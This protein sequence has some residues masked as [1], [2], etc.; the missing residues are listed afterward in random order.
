MLVG[1]I[2]VLAAVVAVVAVL[3][4]DTTGRKGSGLG[5]EFTYDLSKLRKIDPR[6]VGYEEADGIEL[7]LDEPRGLALGTDGRILA[8]GDRKILVFDKGGAQLSEVKLTGSPQC[9]AVASDGTLYVAM[10]DHV[11]VHDPSGKPKATWD[12]LGKDAVLTGIAV[13]DNDVF[14]ADAGNRVVVRYDA[15]GKLLGRIGQKDKD[16]N[17]PGILVP[18]PYM[19]LAVGAEGLLW[20][21]NPGRR[22]V[23]AYTFDGDRESSWGK[24]SSAIDGFCGCCN[25]THLALFP[26]GRVVTSEKGLPRVKVL[27]ADGALKCVVAGPEQFADDARGLDLAVDPRGRILVLDPSAK[28]VRIFTQKEKK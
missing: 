1:A 5:E 7:G 24:S 19:D 6:L 27:D 25:P 17:I 16:K 3:S 13:A 11:E 18:S 15:A 20:V 12:S 9:L 4:T 26:D 2:V 23:E 8:A 10:L 28:R 21:T 14:V 22:L